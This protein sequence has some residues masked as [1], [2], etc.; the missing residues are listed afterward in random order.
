MLCLLSTDTTPAGRLLYCPM[1]GGSPVSPLC[2]LWHFVRRGFW[3][4]LG[5]GCKNLPILPCLGEGG[6]HCSL[7]GL[8]WHWGGGLRIPDHRSDP[9]LS[10]RLP[11]TPTQQRWEG[12]S[13]TSQF[14]DSVKSGLPTSSPLT[15]QG[16]GA[17]DPTGIK[18]RLLSCFSATSPAG[19]WGAS[20]HL[21]RV[22]I[23]ALH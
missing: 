15:R 2:P 20:L 19:S 3:F 14:L 18:S 16:R 12:Y 6:S 21:M 1:G 4:L 17:A 22:E 11:L 13:L 8:Q 23:S 5:R 9:W 7:G 10:A